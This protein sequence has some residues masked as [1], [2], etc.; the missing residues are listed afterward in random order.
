MTCNSDVADTLK[1]LRRGMEKK[2]NL[3]KFEDGSV[4]DLKRSAK[5][6]CRK[7]ITNYCISESLK[8]LHA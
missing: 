5:S 7:K 6:E 8:N 3:R 1:V 2:I 4:R